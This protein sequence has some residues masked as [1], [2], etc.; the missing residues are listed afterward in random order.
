MIAR[1]L[2]H[3]RRR[4]RPRRP[5]GTVEVAVPSTETARA[6]HRGAS[7]TTV[8]GCR[9]GFTAACIAGLGHA[10]RG[11]LA[12]E[13][14]RGGSPGRQRRRAAPGPSSSARFGRS[15]D[16]RPTR[17]AGRPRA[18]ARGSAVARRARA[19]RRLRARRSSSDMPPQTPAS[20][21]DCRWPTSGRCRR[22][23]NG[24]RQPCASSICIECGSGVPNR[25]EQLGV[26]IAAGRAVA[27]VHV[28]SAFL[29]PD[30]GTL[31]TVPADVRAGSSG[32]YHLR[33]ALRRLRGVSPRRPDCPQGRRRSA[34]SQGF[35]PAWDEFRLS[36]TSH[37]GLEFRPSAQMRLFQGGSGAGMPTTSAVWRFVSRRCAVRGA[38]AGSRRCRC[39]PCSPRR[40]GGRSVSSDRMANACT[41]CRRV[42]WPGTRP[43]LLPRSIRRP[44][45]RPEVGRGSAVRTRRVPGRT[46]PAGTGRSA[47]GPKNVQGRCSG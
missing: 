18:D 14:L 12:R 21:P 35:C 41:S 23:R 32:P 29:H 2:V 27:P 22:P 45:A 47:N 42:S 30:P 40:A 7:P 37:S 15:Q 43:D 11:H 20:W 1:E 24:G 8:R 34:L 44:N 17:R 26:L 10:D 16:E 36:R 33:Y 9:D 3:E 13:D 5:G 25:E 46:R 38:C 31:T 19:L 28:S 6:L 4:A 39:G